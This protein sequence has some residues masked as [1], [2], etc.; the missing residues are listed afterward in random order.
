MSPLLAGPLVLIALCD[1]LARRAARGGAAHIPARV[2]SH[3]GRHTMA[4][5]VLHILITA[6]TRIGL[7]AVGIDSWPVAVLAGT[8]LGVALPLAAAM[9]VRRLG[10]A[11]LLGWR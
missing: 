7:G 4:I 8:V 6:G 3:V 5:F 10:L 2:L 1:V 9:A 11:P